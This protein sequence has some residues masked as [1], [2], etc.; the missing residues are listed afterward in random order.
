MAEQ[1]NYQAQRMGLRAQTGGLQ[2]AEL[3]KAW[4]SVQAERL[5]A[6]TGTGDWLK[7]WDIQQEQNPW[8]M[9]RTLDEEI[10]ATREEI[11]N[12][13]AVAKIIRERQKDPTDP[14]F[15]NIDRPDVAT[16]PEQ[17]RAHQ[18]MSNLKAAEDKLVE[19]TT[20][21]D[22]IEGRK[23]AEV[24]VSAG[25]GFVQPTKP[26]GPATPAWLSKLEPT[27]GATVGKMEPT[28]PS[29]Q[30]W[31]RLT[32]SQQ[33]KWGGW[34]EWGGYKPEDILFQ[35]QQ[36]LPRPRTGTRWSAARQRTSV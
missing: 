10:M 23:G 13:G 8:K 14:L 7:K 29:G 33:Q 26:T 19:W 15:V 1:Y 5:A 18:I 31:G 25:E 34:A 9:Q 2:Q 36:M 4:E 32:P 11:K 28:P 16:T 24:P 30:A 35:T 22:Y 17:W 12:L 21:P 27:M 3:A 20:S 6:T